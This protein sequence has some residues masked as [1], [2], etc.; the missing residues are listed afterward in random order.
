MKLYQAYYA[1]LD[2]V[3]FSRN[4]THLS[5]EEVYDLNLYGCNFSNEPVY[6]AAANTALALGT[7]RSFQ[8]FGGSIEGYSSGIIAS[9][10]SGVHLY[11]VYFETGSGMAAIG[12]YLGATT[13]VNLHMTGCTIYLNGH[14]RFVYAQDGATKTSITSSGNFF[15]SGDE[16]SN[17][18]DAFSLNSH[19]SSRNY[20]RGDNWSGVSDPGATYVGAFLSQMAVANSIIEFPAGYDG[21]AWGPE[22]LTFQGHHMNFADGAIISSGRSTGLQFGGDIDEKFGFFGATP[23]NRQPANADTS[24]ASLG[25]L[26]TEVNQLKQALRNLG[27]LAP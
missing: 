3:A 17:A 11:G 9:S 2:R 13:G 26:E 23:V 25:D 18:G 24:G 19:A 5:C 6:G 4:E 27:F 10:G 21:S 7:I 20:L 16:T 8:M 14:T 22:P 15:C 1:V 12:V